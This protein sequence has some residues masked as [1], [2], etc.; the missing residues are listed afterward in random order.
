MMAFG[1]GVNLRRR[2]GALHSHSCPGCGECV[3][4]LCNCDK[5]EEGWYCGALPFQ[6]DRCLELEDVGEYWD[7]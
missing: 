6:E 3:E 2:G 5:P 1:F 7:E 4:N